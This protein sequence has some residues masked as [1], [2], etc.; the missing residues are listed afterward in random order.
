VE[1]NVP[2][3]LIHIGP[4]KTGTT[5]LQHAFSQL[6]SE[7]AARGVLYPD[8]WGNMH[9]HHRL[10]EAVA[11]GSGASLRAAFDQLSRSG[12]DTILLSSETFAYSS[13]SEV[14]QLRALL[15]GDPAT[16]VFYCRRWSELIPSHWREAVKHGSLTTLPEFTLSCLGDPVASEVV[17]FEHVLS[18]YASA[19]GPGALRVV[20]YNS[21]LEAGMDLL[22][23]FCRHFL[24]WPNPPPTNLGRVNE[25]LDMVDSEIIRALNALEWTRAR[26][27]RQRLYEPFLTERADL[28]VRWLVEKSMQYTVDSIRIDDAAASLARLHASLAERY[29]TALVPPFPVSSL[30]KPR[31]AD[32]NYVRTDYLFADGV[33]DTLRDMQMKLL[34]P[35]R[36]GE[37]HVEQGAAGT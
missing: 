17:N 25:S 33:M 30:F 18:R 32:V 5:Y 28:P 31:C 6:R 12:A 22:T 27:K 16:V 24:N 3:Y 29:K 8:T 4:H 37:A 35:G 19:F 7:L 36:F 11:S 34:R 1:T 23:H 13:D 21:I 14:A 15:A 2:R 20:S 26:E 9:G 10:V